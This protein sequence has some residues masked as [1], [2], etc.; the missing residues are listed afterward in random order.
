MPKLDTRA[1]A[2]QLAKAGVDNPGLDARL[3]IAHVLKCDRAQLL[4]RDGGEITDEEENTIKTLLARRANHEPVARIL[5]LREFWGLPFDL[6]EATLEPRPDTETVIEGVLELKPREASRILDLGTGTGCLL[7]SLLHELPDATGLGVD[8]APRAIEQAQANAE[9]LGL[10][11]RAAFKTNN[12]TDNI[13]EKFDVIV[14]N[15]PY[16][17][18]AE[19]PTLMPEV[20]DF[21]P[22]AALDG[23]GDGLAAYRHI[24]PRLPSLLNPNGLVAF[25]IGQGQET[26]VV[27]LFEKTGQFRTITTRK[28]L[29]GI[30]RCV[31]AQR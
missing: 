27:E 21:D 16:I 28:D 6:N 1:Y 30:T 4:L 12:W 22:K 10:A 8:I 13:T 24:C 15:P 7:L 25:E 19:I 18:S 2:A 9:R 20:R 3:L 5:G 26:T 17:K 31:L 23:G 29:N 11:N 14:S